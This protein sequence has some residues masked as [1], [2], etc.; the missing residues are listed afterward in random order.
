MWHVNLNKASQLTP[1]SGDP[2]TAV[3]TETAEPSPAQPL[4]GGLNQVGICW[5][6]AEIGPEGD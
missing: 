4:E 2:D 3:R 5:I 6:A 1:G